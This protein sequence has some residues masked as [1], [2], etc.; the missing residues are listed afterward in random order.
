MGAQYFLHNRKA[1]ACALLVLAAGQ[2]SFVET[3]E[4]QLLVFFGNADAGI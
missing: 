4:D 2:V 3:V 1:E